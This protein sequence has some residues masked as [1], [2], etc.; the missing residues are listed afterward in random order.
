MPV[1]HARMQRDVDAFHKLPESE[2]D[3]FL[4][5]R[6]DPMERFRQRARRMMGGS[7]WGGLAAA[8]AFALTRQWTGRTGCDGR[9]D[10]GPSG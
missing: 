3:A 8:G 10:D 2:R 5:E 4:D 1:M 7:S 6:I 9:Q